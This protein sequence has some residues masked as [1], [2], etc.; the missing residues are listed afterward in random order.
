MVH[1]EIKNNYYQKKRKTAAAQ[2]PNIVNIDSL[3]TCFCLDCIHR[4]FRGNDISLLA[5]FSVFEVLHNF[6]SLLENFYKLPNIKE[7]S[8]S[9]VFDW[10]ERELNLLEKGKIC[11]RPEVWNYVFNK[12]IFRFFITDK[13]KKYI[14][15][16][17]AQEAL[18]ILFTHKDLL[19]KIKHSIKE[20]KSVLLELMIK[21][22]PEINPNILI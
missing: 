10:Y 19:N 4:Y 13:R 12:K 21:E 2:K 16:Q 3:Y 8:F 9:G 1:R 20:Y 7:M 14:E 15:K 18:D 22:T 11:V 6:H 5:I 17:A